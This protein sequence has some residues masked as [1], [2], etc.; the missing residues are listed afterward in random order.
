MLKEFEDVSVVWNHTEC[1]DMVVSQDDHALYLL[2][3]ALLLSLVL[4]VLDTDF[5]ALWLHL[6]SLPSL[7][8]SR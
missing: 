7:P 2:R 6:C 1:E 3:K 8:F 4:I 5:M